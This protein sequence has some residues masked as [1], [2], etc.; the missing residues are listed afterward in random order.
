MRLTFGLLAFTVLWGQ[1]PVVQGMIFNSE[2]HQPLLGVHV[3]FA[4]KSSW[5]RPMYGAVSGR[6]GKF[7]MAQLVPGLYYVTL[8]LTGYVAAQ[9]YND[10][11]EM[12]PA[13][14]E[15]KAGQ[16]Q[17]EL[18]LE[19][20]RRAVIRGRVLDDSG[21][22]APYATVRLV[23]EFDHFANGYS[24]ESDTL[25]NGLGEF[26]MSCLPGRY[27]VVATFSP[28][29]ASPGTG[30][31]P[32]PRLRVTYSETFFPSSTA[33]HA[34]VVAVAPG[35]EK[36][37][38]EIRMVREQRLKVSGKVNGIPADGCR[39]AMSAHYKLSGRF[40]AMP[41]DEVKMDAEGNFAFTASRRGVYRLDAACPPKFSSSSPELVLDKS[42]ITNLRIDLM[43]AMGLEGTLEF[44]GGQ[45]KLARELILKRIGSTF[46]GP[47]PQMQTFLDNDGIFRFSAIP[48]HS[49]EVSMRGMKPDE[50]IQAIVL[51]GAAVAGPIDFSR[52]RP[53]RM[54]VVVGRAGRLSGTIIGP[55]KP[56]VRY[57]MTV[58]LVP[59][60]MPGVTENGA[61]SAYL[62]TVQPSVESA[63]SFDS[64][65][66][67]KYRL[68]AIDALHLAVT[69]LSGLQ[70]LAASAALIEIVAGERTTK[71][72]TPLKFAFT[73][74]NEK[75]TPPLPVVSG[76]GG[77]RIDQ[78]SA[79]VSTGAI[80]GRV[81]TSDGKPIEGMLVG[82]SQNGRWK[83]FSL[84]DDRG[85]FRIVNLPRGVYRVEARPRSLFLQ[86]HLIPEEI[87][88][89]G[90]SEIQYARTFYPD[91]L[92]DALAVP[93]SVTAG[94]ETEGLD[95][96]LQAGPVLRISGKVI[97]ELPADKNRLI[98]L[99]DQY[100]VD[101][102]AAKIKGDGTF[103]FWRMNA[104]RYQLRVL[105]LCAGGPT[106]NVAVVVG[107][108]PVDNVEI[109]IP[110]SPSPSG[111]QGT[112]PCVPP[113]IGIL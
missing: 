40:V 59:D 31:A 17:P 98:S 91:V 30:T 4:T 32:D 25:A 60:S 53:S 15:V 108:S 50:F 18:N 34:S 41:G 56:T 22:P 54:K 49:F 24:P 113:R 1:N 90:T 68:L 78:Q 95:I 57:P 35:E 71:D 62:R 2:T 6:D 85:A 112:Q 80:A 63:Y 52:I 39:V 61:E 44:V 21:N 16:Q 7:S 97:T 55:E 46:F 69:G 27:R 12:I 66:P 48:P 3:R 74:A 87:R 14:V 77:S 101:Y 70:Q 26:R 20:V 37:D 28:R 75:R 84:T 8:E 106:L 83:E 88:T 38:V 92:E 109:K 36:G 102:G 58:F 82:A 42:D 100:G 67:G 81:R 65:R 94:A 104:G 13:Y 43:A 96:R 89:D 23:E 107:R 10:A 76:A 72:L 105:P 47:T 11:G 33:E 99:S 110:A 93:I 73:T 45:E 79:K 64:I 5:D 9:S 86:S 103:E 51:D 111:N 19:M 29:P